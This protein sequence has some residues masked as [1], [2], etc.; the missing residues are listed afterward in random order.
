MKK[1]QK[2]GLGASARKTGRSRSTLQSSP[3]KAKD[4]RSDR[5]RAR[6][7]G[8]ELP[9]EVVAT[10]L[11]DPRTGNPFLDQS[12]LPIFWNS[13]VARKHGLSFGDL[14][15]AKATITWEQPVHINSPIAF[16]GSALGIGAARPKGGVR[17]KAK[18]GTRAKPGASRATPKKSSNK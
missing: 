13:G 14:N 11:L 5:S 4:F 3:K 17:S 2:E 16:L 8:R 9:R 15:W 6:A 7:H 18:D 1:Q 12:R 10:I